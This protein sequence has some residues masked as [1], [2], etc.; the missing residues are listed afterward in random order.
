MNLKNLIVCLAL[1]MLSGPSVSRAEHGSLPRQTANPPSFTD[2][3]LGLF[4]SYTY[5][6]EAL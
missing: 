5:V 6:G 1:T 2:M 4:A 3:H